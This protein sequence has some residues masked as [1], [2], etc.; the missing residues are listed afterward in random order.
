M[1]TIKLVTGIFGNEPKQYEVELGNKRVNV[2]CK[3]EPHV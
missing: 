1:K 3:R 2:P